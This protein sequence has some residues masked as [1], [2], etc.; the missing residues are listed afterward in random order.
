MRLSSC[1]AA[2]VLALGALSTVLAEA[3][4]YFY[5]KVTNETQWEVLVS[6]P[7]PAQAAPRAVLH[8]RMHT[9]THTH[10]CAYKHTGAGCPGPARV[11]GWAP[12]LLRPYHRRERMA[13][14]FGR[15]HNVYI[16]L[17]P[18]WFVRAD[19]K[20]CRSL[21]GARRRTQRTASSTTR[22]TTARSMA[23]PT[24]LTRRP[25]RRRGISQM[26]LRGN[27]SCTRV[28]CKTA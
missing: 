7:H 5:N 17:R 4:V 28:N 18:L 27:V 10:A 19:Q 22:S 16:Y 8:A 1:L 20:S 2:G 15:S 3:G 25:A 12:L 13:G 14:A 24:T 9:H 11:G 26:S 6:R 21:T 23:N